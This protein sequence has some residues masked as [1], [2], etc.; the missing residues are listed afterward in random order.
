VIDAAGGVTLNNAAAGTWKTDAANKVQVKKNDGTTVSFDVVWKFNSDNHLVV[1]AGGKELDFNT[2]GNNVPRYETR[3][4]VIVVAP[5]K[6]KPFSFELAG[7]WTLS[8]SHDLSV[9]I[10]GTTSVIDGFI[11]DLRSRFMFHF[12]DKKKPLRGS[13]FGFV[14]AW[15]NTQ[16]DDGT[17]MLKFTYKRR[18]KP[19]G[20]L[21][22]GVF[23]LPKG[24]AFNK[25]L[26]Q[27]EYKYTKGGKERSITFIGVLNIDEN[28]QLTYGLTR[29]TTSDNE[30]QVTGTTFTIGA[31]FKKKNFSG[32]LDLALQKSDGKAGATTFTIGGHFTAV[33]GAVTLRAGFTFTQTHSASPGPNPPTTTSTFGFNT[34]LE[35]KNG[36]IQV[37]FL[38]SNTTT[39]SITLSV[40]AD[41]R[42]GKVHIDSTLNLTMDGQQQGVT[43][44]LGVTITD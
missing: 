38:T 18:R 36:S 14:G 23:E 3:D 28:F 17:A 1:S 30:E 31:V 44:M 7:V 15:E 40:N 11:N 29:Q 9:T 39:R 42:L 19:E 24:V 33:R 34:Q 43:F 10:N 4:A 2:V 25:T 12:A 41:I 13:V 22:E 27:L 5:N 26:N 6:D 8:P 16:T 32:D 37:T 35:F 20:D 21:V